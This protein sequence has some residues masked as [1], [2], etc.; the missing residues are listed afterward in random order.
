MTIRHHEQKQ[1]CDKFQF[2]QVITVEMARRMDTASVGKVKAR[3]ERWCSNFFSNSGSVAN[4]G[5]IDVVLGL[6]PLE[7]GAVGTGLSLRK[8]G[9]S[10][11]SGFLKSKRKKIKWKGSVLSMF[12]LL[13]V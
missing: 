13:G 2:Y 8:V 3:S 5:T 10:A 6:G 11:A 4:S 12:T 9:D 1:M 7:V